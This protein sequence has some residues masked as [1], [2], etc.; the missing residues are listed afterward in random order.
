MIFYVLV[1]GMRGTTYV[2]V[3]KASLLVVG[4]LV[5]TSGCSASTGS[6]CPR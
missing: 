5:M 2:Q 3:I 1:G 6:A 4:A